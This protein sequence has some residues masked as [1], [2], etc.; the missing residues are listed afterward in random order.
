MIAGRHVTISFT[1]DNILKYLGIFLVVKWES[2]LLFQMAYIFKCVE[3]YCCE[4]LGSNELCECLI[5]QGIKVAEPGL[6]PRSTWLWT[7]KDSNGPFNSK[8]SKPDYDI[9]SV[10]SPSMTSS[11]IIPHQQCP[12]MTTQT[13]PRLF[14]YWPRIPCDFNFLS[15]LCGILSCFSRVSNIVP[16][17]FPCIFCI[18]LQV[19]EFRWKFWNTCELYTWNHMQESEQN[20][21]CLAGLKP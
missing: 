19:F 3:H 11:V 13:H 17:C 5:L 1:S 4:K 21:Q 14:I 16:S 2:H 12:S 6:E 8:P 18:K 15:V 7:W 9:P 20:H 10:T